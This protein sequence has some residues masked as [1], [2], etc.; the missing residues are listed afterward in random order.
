MNWGRSPNYQY[1]LFLYK[2]FQLDRLSDM[3]I[4]LEATFGYVANTIIYAII[5]DKEDYIHIGII[6]CIIVSLY[7]K[8]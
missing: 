6:I 7:R 8:K 3:I 4:N 5:E 2:S 1:N